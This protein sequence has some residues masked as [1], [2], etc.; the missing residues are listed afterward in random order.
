[1]TYLDAVIKESMRLL[2]ASRIGIRQATQDMNICG[3]T[4]P[5]GSYLSFSVDCL[6]AIDPLLWNGD[7][8][9]AVP[10]HMDWRNNLQGTFKP[11]R[12][13]TDS[14]KPKHYYPFGAGAHLCPGMNLVYAEVKLLISKMLRGGYSWTFEQGGR[15]LREGVKVFP[16]IKVLAGMDEL[17]IRKQH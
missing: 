6:H 15:V 16:G 13:L 9:N 8:S 11:S 4:V 5:A 12:W 10:D 14:T 17:I 1:M 2:S 3:Y 7:T